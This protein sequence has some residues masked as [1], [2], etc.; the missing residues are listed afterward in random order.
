MKTAFILA[1]GKGTRLLDITKDEIP[2][3][4]VEVCNKSIIE[5]E[6]ELLKNYGF[7]KVY[8]SVNH[9]KEKIMDKLQDGKKYGLSI[10]YIV[11]NAPL[12]SGGALFYVKD[13][14]K[15]D[16]FVLSGD[17]ILDIDFDRMLSFHNK[18][19]ALATLFVHPNVHPYDSD[20]VITNNNNQIIKFDFKDNVR[21]NYY[22]NLVNA[23]IFI[24]SPT[25]L[26]YFTE[27]KKVNM[28]KDFLN[29][30]IETK[31][32]YAYKS[33]EYVKDAGTV[34]RI[35]KVTNDI[36]KGIVKAKNLK[37][38]QKAI[39]LDRDGTIN[40]YKGFIANAEEIE[41]L[42]TV[43]DAIKKIN[44]SEYLALVVTNQP[45][46]ARGETTFEEVDN[47]HK[48]IETLLG[49]QGAYVDDITFCPH[50][51]TSG[52]EGEIKELKIDCECR[53]PKIGMIK[54]FEEKYNLDLENS[55]IIGD[56]G[57]DILTGKNAHLKTIK[58]PF[59]FQDKYNDVKPDYF[60]EN[61]LQAVNIILKKTKK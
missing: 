12:G 26:S 33:T 40:K 25:A 50:H 30:L 24:I 28:E 16:F 52:F 47:I 14:I 21:E 2:K 44:N 58:L 48:K 7:E 5:R 27:E 31:R 35:E 20:L 8:I 6:L 46:I 15:E 59:Y 34:D 61:L 23:G 49:Q 56:G 43:I 36:N 53:K 18:N 29:S 17:I 60:A 57:I 10:E 41:L 38:K 19:S 42:P 22:K 45:V 9:L 37:N 4:L 55:Y 51:P 32:V 3:P 54:Y 1:G 13:K 39:F 11:E